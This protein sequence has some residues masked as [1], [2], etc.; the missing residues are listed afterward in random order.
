MNYLRVLIEPD[1]PQAQRESTWF[2]CD[3]QGR[4]LRRGRSEPRHWPGVT[5]GE[6]PGAVQ[7][8]LILCGPQTLC[9]RV[10]LPR[11]ES[12]RRPEILAAALEEYL[13]TD[14]AECQ[15]LVA[16]QD[17]EGYAP[18]AAVARTR[19]AEL[20]GLCGELGLS[21]GSVWP[22]GFLLPTGAGGLLGRASGRNLV[23]PSSGGAY[24]DLEI[25]AHLSNQLENLPDI[26]AARPLAYQRGEVAPDR[27]AFLA[28][29]EADGWLAGEAAPSSHFPL[30]P[31]E[32]AGFL[33][34]DF[35]IRRGGGLLTHL[36]PALGLGAVLV[37]AYFLVSLAQWGWLAWLQHGYRE[38]L[39]ARYR[40]A[41]PEGALV[42][43]VLQMQR[44][45]DTRR[46]LAGEL[47]AGDF[48][49]LLARLETPG[50]GGLLLERLDYGSGRLVA[51]G[52]LPQGQ[53]DLWSA[54]L[55]ARGADIQVTGRAGGGDQGSDRAQVKIQ[56]EA[57]AGR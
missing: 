31:P 27:A 26:D 3:G 54:R 49:Q 29:A 21:L 39:V 36:R 5:G 45:L 30:R 28:A 52:S 56:V 53:V 25:D 6:S 46:R 18:V 19:L 14:P 37:A 47:G 23:L 48:L 55:R 13:L 40:E 12:G 44:Q 20:V 8:D 51:E 15:F 9:Q 7:C 35:Q 11:G 24:L 33:Q 22:E 38:T 17:G 34:G 50:D 2:L 41:F 4:I 42:D 32:G 1:W 43:P 16:A 10:Q 57:G